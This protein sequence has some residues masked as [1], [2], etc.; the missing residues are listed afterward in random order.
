VLLSHS[1]S[2]DNPINPHYDCDL[3]AR[4]QETPWKWFLARTVPCDHL[5]GVH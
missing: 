1:L 3:A 4:L 5:V 2:G